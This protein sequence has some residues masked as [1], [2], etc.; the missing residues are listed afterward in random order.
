MT[1]HYDYGDDF[2]F[3]FLDR[4]ARLYS[5]ALFRSEDDTLEQA[6]QNKLST[7]TR[8]SIADWLTCP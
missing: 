1:Q 7:H 4:Q 3:S 6:A 5:Q 2:Y 8:M